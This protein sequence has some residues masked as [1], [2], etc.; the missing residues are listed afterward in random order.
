[1][2]VAILLSTI[3]ANALPKIIR[4]SFDKRAAA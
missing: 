2:F 1:M 3:A 4:G